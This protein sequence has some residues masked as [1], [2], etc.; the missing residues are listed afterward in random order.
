MDK[1]YVFVLDE[2]PGALFTADEVSVRIV[3]NTIDKA[4]AAYEKAEIDNGGTYVNRHAGLL[5]RRKPDAIAV[6]VTP[7]ALQQP[8]LPEHDAT[9]TDIDINQDI[10]GEG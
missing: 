10:G 9:I 4:S 5:M 3:L 1:Q 7:P 2:Y 8:Q 6:P